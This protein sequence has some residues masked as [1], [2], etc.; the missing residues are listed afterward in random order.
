MGVNTFF[1]IGLMTFLPLGAKEKGRGHFIN[2]F[3]LVKTGAQTVPI[4]HQNN[5][6][7]T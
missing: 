3:R 6:K 7:Q 5:G 1:W 2:P 4:S